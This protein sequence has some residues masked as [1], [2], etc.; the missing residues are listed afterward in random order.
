MRGKR[1]RGSFVITDSTL[2]GG[3]FITNN[4]KSDDN[5]NKPRG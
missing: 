3:K 2:E 5:N 1:P 4:S